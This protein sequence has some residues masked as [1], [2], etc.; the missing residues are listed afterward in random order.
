ME[1]F[2]NIISSP[3]F[4]NITNLCVA[5]GSLLAIIIAIWGKDEIRHCFFHAKLKLKISDMNVQRSYLNGNQVNFFYLKI[6]NSRRR[7]EKNVRVYLNSYGKKNNGQFN[8]KPYPVPLQLVWSP[9]ETTPAIINLSKQHIIDFFKLENDNGIFILKPVLYSTPF[10]FKE[11]LQ[12][13]DCFRFELK[14]V[15]DYIEHSQI[16]EINFKSNPNHTKINDVG[17]DIEISEVKI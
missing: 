9:A 1:C 15:A 5:I 12:G 3:Y 4:S 6:E 13:G 17:S 8:L 10:G 16:F 2:C 11:T 7:I 14:I